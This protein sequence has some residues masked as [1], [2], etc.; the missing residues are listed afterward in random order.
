M[1]VQA[2]G[3]DTITKKGDRSLRMDCRF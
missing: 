3:S 1:P 2:S